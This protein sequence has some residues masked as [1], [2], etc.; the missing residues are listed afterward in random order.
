MSDF[1]TV[2]TDS[3]LDFLDED[4]IDIDAAITTYRTGFGG[5]QSINIYF[6]E[7]SN[8]K[9]IR[10]AIKPDISDHVNRINSTSST[11]ELASCIFNIFKMSQKMN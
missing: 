5:L 8:G 7:S 11:R 9:N 10:H 3:G 4:D 2:E 1:C 6:E